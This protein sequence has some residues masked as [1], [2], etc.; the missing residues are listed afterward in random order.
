MGLGRIKLSALVALAALLIPVGVP[1]ASCPPAN[2]AQKCCCY[3]IICNPCGSEG[4]DTE[5]P[6]PE[7][8]GQEQADYSSA[9]LRFNE[10]FPNPIGSDSENE[11]IE[12]ANRGTEALTLVGWEVHDDKGRSFVFGDEA[13]PGGAEIFLPYSETKIP[14][15]NGGGRLTLHD[16]DGTERNAIEYGTPVPEGSTYADFA[17]G[18][19]WTTTPTPG[20]ANVLSEAEEPAEEEEDEDENTE[21]EDADEEEPEE[22]VTDEPE[23]VAVTLSEIMPNP[24]GD[25]ADGEWIELRNPNDVD[26]DLTGWQL[27]D[28]DGGSNPYELPEGSVVPANG[29]LTVPRQ[30]SKIAL[31]NG[32]D[33]VRLF[34]ADGTLADSVDYT[35]A[36]EGE[37]FAR[38]DDGWLWTATPTPDA[39]NEFPVAAPVDN[40]PTEE[41]P[42]E[43]DPTE[44]VETVPV[45]AAHD[46]PDGTEI[47]V[48][49]VVTL[50]P[51]VIGKTIFGL[52]DT[53]TDYAATVRVYG[54]TV[55]ALA[56]GDVVTVTGKIARK[57][58]GELRIN[59]SAAKMSFLGNDGAVTESDKA[60]AELEGQSAG[61]LVSIEGIVADIGR[62]WFVMTDEGGNHEIKI[63]LPEGQELSLDLDNRVSVKGVVRTQS[64]T[65]ALAVLGSD[66]VI[67]EASPAVDPMADSDDQT[68]ATEADDVTALLPFLTVGAIGAGG[69]AYRGL[70]RRNSGTRKKRPIKG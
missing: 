5:E 58:N 51:G 48:V 44:E 14:L 7:D 36:N 40:E 69:V 30:D 41:E 3:V 20:A 39:Q 28:M 56:E 16:P 15:P 23:P 11:F 47:T 12:L 10:L 1:A 46:L 49:G 55:P 18:W 63:E 54:D 50:P 6:A 52:Q 38:G 32:G 26:A 45:E 35:D 4:E 64:S 21:N 22:E 66:D 13:V 65:L 33:S 17:D 9:D 61:L 29:Y 25:D 59:S 60:L 70:R 67:L 27:D 57:S 68:L 37:A 31:N 8:G 19:S 34:N 43:T 53:D 42:D 24:V 2:E 62:G